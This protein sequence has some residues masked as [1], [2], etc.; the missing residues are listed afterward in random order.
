MLRVPLVHTCRGK[1]LATA[2]LAFVSL[3]KQCSDSVPADTGRT[4]QDRSDSPLGCLLLQK[5]WSG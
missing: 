1:N 3:E 2:Y 4:K 5:P